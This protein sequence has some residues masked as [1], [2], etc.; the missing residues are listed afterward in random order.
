MR[1]GDGLVVG[2]GHTINNGGN[3]IRLGLES[4]AVDNVVSRNR[5]AGILEG[6]PRQVPGEARYLTI[7]YRTT[8]ALA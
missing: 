1:R 8:I 6:F 4:I 5:G 3:G 2:S 7:Q